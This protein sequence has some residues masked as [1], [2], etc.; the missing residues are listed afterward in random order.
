[1]EYSGDADIECG[2]ETEVSSFVWGGV[3]ISY[4]NGD[5]K[6]GLGESVFLYEI[7]VYAGDPGSRIN[8][9]A[10]VNVFQGVRGYH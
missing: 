8:E 4:R 7:P 9:G 2:G 10:G 3:G 5:I 1:M 6:A